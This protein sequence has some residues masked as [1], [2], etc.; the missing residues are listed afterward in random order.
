V[1]GDGVRDAGIG[2]EKW[3]QLAPAAP[4]RTGRGCWRRRVELDDI[5]GAISQAAITEI[6]IGTGLGPLERLEA[7]GK[8]GSS[9]GPKARPATGLPSTVEEW[10]RAAEGG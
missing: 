7:M 8:M 6:Y 3:A 1:P 4:T 9:R 5:K 2:S 10:A